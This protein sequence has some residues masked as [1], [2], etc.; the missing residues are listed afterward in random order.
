M[1]KIVNGLPDKLVEMDEQVT[2]TKQMSDDAGPIMQINK[3]NVSPD[4]VDQFLEGFAATAEGPETQAWLNHK[5]KSYAKKNGHK[6]GSFIHNQKDI[7]LIH[8]NQK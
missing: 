5:I 6:L 3:F 7:W 8:Q 1:I 4:E 2:I